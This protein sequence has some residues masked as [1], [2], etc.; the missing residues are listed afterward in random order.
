MLG[1]ITPL[2]ERARGRRWGVTVT[3]YVMASAFGGV[4]IGAALGAFGS[5]ATPGVGATLRML[6]IAVAAAVGIVA[7]AH[8]G[9]I[10]VPSVARQV[11]ADWMS[12]YREWVYGAGFGLQLG[13][14]VVTVVTTSAV[15][16]MLVAAFLSGG[17]AGGAL[18]AGTFGALRGAT[19]LTASG[20][21][22]AE[23]LARVRA[24]LDRWDVPARTGSIAIQGVVAAALVVGVAR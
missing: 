18:V 17:V 19:I 11:N 4:A 5:V 3:A 6:A 22:R 8:L 21:R 9:G 16:A 7:D 1:S 23:Q 24:A 13:L 15:Y 12:R 14:A 10:H 20:V 2:G